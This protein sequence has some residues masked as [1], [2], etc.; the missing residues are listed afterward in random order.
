M[1]QS[2]SKLKEEKM[3]MSKALT[4]QKLIILCVRCMMFGDVLKL[5]FLLRIKDHNWDKEHADVVDGIDGPLV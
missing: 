5:F 3:V 1:M 2:M 4:P